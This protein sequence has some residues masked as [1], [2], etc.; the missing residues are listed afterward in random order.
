MGKYT[1]EEMETIVNWNMGTRLTVYVSSAM[2]AVWRA[3]Q[4]IGVKPTVKNK[5]NR[6][7]E[8][9]GARYRITVS[10]GRLR[11]SDKKNRKPMSP[12][13]KKKLQLAMAKMKKKK[14]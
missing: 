12:E 1:K 11:I 4:R 10:N 14:G 3:F 9:D 8:I 7:Y 2:P 5:D 13:V 6:Q